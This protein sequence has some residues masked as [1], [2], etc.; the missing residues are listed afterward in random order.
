MAAIWT[1]AIGLPATVAVFYTNSLSVVRHQYGCHTTQ[2]FVSYIYVKESGTTNLSFTTSADS[3]APGFLSL[4]GSLVANSRY[5]VIAKSMI[6]L[7]YHAITCIKDRKTN[8]NMIYFILIA[9]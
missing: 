3:K 7:K 6:L 4:A 5:N 8:K 2:M 9:L 1:E